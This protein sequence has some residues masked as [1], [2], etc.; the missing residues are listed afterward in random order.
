MSLEINDSETSEQ[1]KLQEDADL[2]MNF[3][4]QSLNS[5]AT[6]FFG[7]KSDIAKYLGKCTNYNIS[8][9]RLRMDWYKRSPDGIILRGSN[10]VLEYK[11]SEVGAANV[12]LLSLARNIV[13][14]YVSLHTFE[15]KR[16]YWHRNSLNLFGDD[17]D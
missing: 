13:E 12:L 5:D 2:V 7:D 4:S 17:P 14:G 6:Q 9:N 8:E 10:V 15:V 16:I 1:V 3:I 11:S